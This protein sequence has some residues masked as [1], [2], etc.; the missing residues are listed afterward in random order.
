MAEL[1]PHAPHGWLVFVQNNDAAQFGETV[2]QIVTPEGET[3]YLRSGGCYS[4]LEGHFAALVKQM[5]G[6]ALQVQFQEAPAAAPLDMLLF[7]PRCG[8]QHIDAPEGEWENPPHRS[9]K[10]S[11]CEAIWRPSD[12]PTNGIAA[13]NTKGAGEH[14][15]ASPL[16]NGMGAA[17]HAELKRQFDLGYDLGYN[18]G[19]SS[20]SASWVLAL[21]QAAAPIESPADAVTYI[22]LLEAQIRRAHE[23]LNK[24]VG[25]HPVQ[26]KHLDLAD[27]IDQVMGVVEIAENIDQ[28]RLFDQQTPDAKTDSPILPT[29]ADPAGQKCPP[30]RHQFLNSI[31]VMC[32]EHLSNVYP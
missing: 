9:H 26:G 11:R 23:A 31:C 4:K 7:C 29:P 24:A 25:I 32:G 19:E 10:C 22:L 2:Y 14:V 15:N 16:A 20:G 13:L 3:F 21:D 27:R 28:G 8:H 18:E 12:F 5:I 30:D 1:I 6:T 17:F